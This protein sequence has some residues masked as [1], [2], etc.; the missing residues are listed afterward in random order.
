MCP[1]LVRRHSGSHRR[2]PTS[3]ERAGVD[4]TW[5]AREHSRLHLPP[6]EDHGRLAVVLVVLLVRKHV[7]PVGLLKVREVAVDLLL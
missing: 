2:E 3:R 7:A 5:Q 4:R 6:I 1:D